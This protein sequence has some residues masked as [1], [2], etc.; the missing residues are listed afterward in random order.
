MDGQID[1]QIGRQIDTKIFLYLIWQSLPC[2]KQVL[3]EKRLS[4][5]QKS[6]Q[7]GASCS[8]FLL[9]IFT[10]RNL[11]LVP[12]KDHCHVHS[13]M[14]TAKLF[15]TNQES[16]VG[17]RIFIKF[18]TFLADSS[19]PRISKQ[20]SFVFLMAAIFPNCNNFN[21]SGPY[22]SCPFQPSFNEFQ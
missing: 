9:L 13:Q 8:F 20:S 19:F 4:F 16:S 21:F 15:N 1:K 5:S 6:S 17:W 2:N 3:K 12:Y 14:K 10:L 22:S 7:E 18:L 11:C